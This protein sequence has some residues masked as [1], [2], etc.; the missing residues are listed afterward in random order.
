M[1]CLTWVYL[2][3]KELLQSEKVIQVLRAHQQKVKQ[4]KIKEIQ[5][6]KIKKEQ[7][8]K[9]DTVQGNVRKLLA[10]VHF[11]EIHCIYTPFPYRQSW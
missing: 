6:R 10:V 1:Y 5:E 4:D 9:E 3:L 11:L 8:P 2:I 7:E